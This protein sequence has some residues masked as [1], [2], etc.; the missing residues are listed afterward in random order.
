MLSI[1]S[2]VFSLGKQHPLS[3]VRAACRQ[4]SV[5]LVSVSHVS[6]PP[7]Y[8]YG[9]VD[10]EVKPAVPAPA[11][12]ASPAPVAGGKRAHEVDA[13]V[14]ASP[15]VKQARIVESQP[16][17]AATA[18]LLFSEPRIVESQPKPA[19]T[20]PLLFSEPRIVESQPKPAATAPAAVAL[21]PVSVAARPAEKQQQPLKSVGG[22][23][24]EGDDEDDDDL[25]DAQIVDE[26]PDDS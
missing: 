9:S 11:P 18:P 6:L 4:A 16:K 7:L 1:A 19:A 3:S 25:G 13:V 2:S 14:E 23:D 21:Q 24:D 8:E 17:P 26:D 20:A 15:K 5:S 12:T 10:F 22:E